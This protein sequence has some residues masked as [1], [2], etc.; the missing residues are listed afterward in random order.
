MASLED[1]FRAVEPH[2]G[3]RQQLINCL[4][5]EALFHHKKGPNLLRSIFTTFPYE[6]SSSPE[7]QEFEEL[8]VSHTVQFAK[9]KYS[10]YFLQEVLERGSDQLQENI[11]GRVLTGNLVILSL[12]KHGSH[13]HF[14]DATM[15]LARRIPELPG[16]GREKENQTVF[17]KK[18]MK[19]VRE[20]LS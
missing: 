3:L 5:N 12:D 17:V 19:A 10:N 8:I 2:T 20:V 18:V 7:N 1:L 16:V 9:G 13:V 6:D 11:T 14:S 15:A 4:L